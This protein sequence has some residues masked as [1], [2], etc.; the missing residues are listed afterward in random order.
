M[1]LWLRSHENKNMKVTDSFLTTS[2]NCKNAIAIE[3]SISSMC[4]LDIVCKYLH[5]VTDSRAPAK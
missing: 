2:I 1:I 4:T 3:E 5:V